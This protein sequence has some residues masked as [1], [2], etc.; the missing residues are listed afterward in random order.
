VNFK[1]LSLIGIAASLL[2]LNMPNFALIEGQ[3]AIKRTVYTHINNKTNRNIDIDSESNPRITLIPGINNLEIQDLKLFKSY[4]YEFSLSVDD[5]ST[6]ENPFLVLN[7]SKDFGTDNI[8]FETYTT[9][10]P[11][12][13]PGAAAGKMVYAIILPFDEK[14]QSV[15]LDL[16]ITKPDD[17]DLVLDIKNLKSQKQ[18]LEE[19]QQKASSAL[20]NILQRD[21]K[22]Q[23]IEELKKLKRR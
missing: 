9:Y 19:K 2:L 17:Q 10:Y 4:T 12:H 15:I 8:Q 5:G 21:Q 11:E 7:Y 6:Q 20:L 16:E 1:Q 13:G 3:K 23:S 14:N 22:Y 18:E